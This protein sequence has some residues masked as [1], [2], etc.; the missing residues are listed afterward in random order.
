MCQNKKLRRVGRAFTFVELMVVIVILAIAAAIVVPM[1][2]SGSAMQLRAAVNMV[3]ADLEYAK[4]LAISRGQMYSVVFDT[5]AESYQIEDPNGTVIPHPVKK[6]FLYVVNFHTDGRLG[7]VNIV[8][9]NFNAGNRVKFDYLGSPFDSA[10][11]ALNSGVVT[12]KV[13]TTTRT[14]T[15]EPVTGFIKVSN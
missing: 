7:Q 8:S 9:A 13:G 5:A 10:D 15:V 3:S 2:S 6:G 11:S 1:A 14:V 12:L 4:S